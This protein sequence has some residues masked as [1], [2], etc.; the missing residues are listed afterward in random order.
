MIQPLHRCAPSTLSSLRLVFR[1]ARSHTRSL[2]RSHTHRGCIC[3]LSSIATTPP[4]ARFGYTRASS[5]SSSLHADKEKAQGR[6]EE[7]VKIRDREREREGGGMVMSMRQASAMEPANQASALPPRPHHRCIAFS[8]LVSF[9]VLSTQPPHPLSPSPPQA[10][11]YACTY[12]PKQSG[13]G[14]GDDL[15]RRRT[16]GGNRRLTHGGHT[17]D[18]PAVDHC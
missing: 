12:A 13:F 9:L 7:A 11:I 16:D 5:T 3:Y 10:C 18:R 2:A 1:A 6:K 8:L 17:V 4:R 14:G 15:A